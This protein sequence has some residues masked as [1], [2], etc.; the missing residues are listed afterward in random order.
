MKKGRNKKVKEIKWGLNEYSSANKMV[1][2]VFLIIISAVILFFFIPNIP[3]INDFIKKHRVPTFLIYGVLITICVFVLFL[4][5]KIK[6]LKYLLFANII[7]VI[8]CTVF[9]IKK[10]KNENLNV[11]V[12]FIAVILYIEF[13]SFASYINESSINEFVKNNGKSKLQYLFLFAIEILAFAFIEWLIVYLDTKE[14]KEI[15]E[16]EL[17]ALF[18]KSI[19]QSLTAAIAIFGL[20]NSGLPNL[21]VLITLVIDALAAF[22]YPILDMIQYIREKEIEFSE[23]N[24]APIRPIDESKE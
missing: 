23:K 2:V 1:A 5:T 15:D 11:A 12:Y 19:F 22:S 8:T 4:N 10:A 18:I 14:T 20:S 9:A 13:V 7:L 3:R 17:E 16:V 21:I 24:F 6:P